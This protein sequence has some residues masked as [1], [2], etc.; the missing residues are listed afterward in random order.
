MLLRRASTKLLKKNGLWEVGRAGMA[1]VE[2]EVEAVM[3][4][5]GVLKL[6]CA[7]LGGGTD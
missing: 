7:R 3:A 4:G 5:N 6:I 2:G 1:K